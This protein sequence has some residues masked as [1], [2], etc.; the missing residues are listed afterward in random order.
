MLLITQQSSASLDSSAADDRFAGIAGQRL[1]IYDIS[2]NDTIS[3]QL[4]LARAEWP[5]AQCESLRFKC[6]VVL[7]V[8][9]KSALQ[10][11][12]ARAS[13]PP[14]GLNLSSLTRGALSSS[15]Y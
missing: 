2:Y 15:Q 10:H 5:N 13:M 9:M 4:Q 6:H 3:H 1:L 12:F 8:H 14:I 11:M 7:V